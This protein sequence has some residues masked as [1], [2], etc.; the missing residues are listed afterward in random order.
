MEIYFLFISWQKSTTTNCLLLSVISSKYYNAYPFYILHIYNIV[1]PDLTFKTI[2]LN[3]YLFYVSLK[4]IYYWI[5]TLD[6]LLVLAF[7]WK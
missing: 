3:L 5:F 1:M 6:L 4:K 7:M 2:D